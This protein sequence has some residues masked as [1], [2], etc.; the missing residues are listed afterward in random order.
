MGRDRQPLILVVNDDEAMRN[1]LRFALQLEGVE[2]HSHGDGAD[3]LADCDLRRA[4][5]LILKDRIP[6]MDGFEVMKNL[7]ARDALPPTILLT[8]NATSELHAR[9]T[10]AGVRLVLENPILDNAL[11]EGVLTILADGRT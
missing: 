4:S 6:N 9:A 1:A 8:A 5:C 7:S 10:A 3:L 2:V 11:V